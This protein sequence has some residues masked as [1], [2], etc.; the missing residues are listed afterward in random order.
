MKASEIKAAAADLANF[1]MVKDGEYVWISDV[2]DYLAPNHPEM[3]RDEIRDAIAA[4]PR[5]QM[6]FGRVDIPAMHPAG[7]VAASR[8]V[9]D[10]REAH[11]IVVR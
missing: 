3:S 2:V 4:V 9:N 8:V 5:S 6:S 10:G 7:K 1:G 11:F